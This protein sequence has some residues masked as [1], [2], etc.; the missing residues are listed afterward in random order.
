M[1]RLLAAS[2]G[3][4]TIA[5]ALS[6]CGGGDGDARST[7]A[8]N[9]VENKQQAL[10]E[11]RTDLKTKADG[12][13]RSAATYIGALD[14]YGDVLTGTAPTVGDVTEAGADLT[15][16][17]SDVISSAEQVQ[18]A[19]K[20]VATAEQELAAAQAALAALSSA[21]PA[22]SAS[23]SPSATPLVAASTVDR[24][25]QA[26]A[27][28]TAAQQGVSA[29]SALADAAEKFNSAAVALEMAWL[30]LF[31]EAGCLTDEQHQQAKEAARDYTLALQK[32]LAEADYYQGEIDGVYGPTTVA[33][34]TALQKKHGLPE[35]GTVDKA[36]D[37]ALRTDLAAKGGAAASQ[38]VASTAAVQQTL[39]LAGH[40]SGPVD[41]TW[42]P[43]LT[44]ALK[45]FQTELGVKPTGAVDSATIA[46]VQK[47]VNA[48]K[49]PSASPSPSASK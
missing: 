9:R 1:K 39:K 27:D 44:E 26:D 14:R 41:G 25:K 12:F 30:R 24:V 47:K 13:C 34:V 17:R 19:K 10:D 3:T 5:L 43:A 6:G 31:E 48:P 28:F 20:A 45:A 11:A 37:A 40:W 49:Q 36:T 18:E 16:P 23:P 15:E 4:M 22:P 42:T 8:Q 29:K 2:A 33:A 21:S 46:A 32:S 7:V 35:T 38:E